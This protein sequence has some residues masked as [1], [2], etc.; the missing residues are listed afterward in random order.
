MEVIIAIDT[1]GKWHIID[2]PEGLTR[3]LIALTDALYCAQEAQKRDDGPTDL[4]NMLAG[5][6]RSNWDG[7][8]FTDHTILWRG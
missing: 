4:T 6:Y 5:L 8:K 3:A 1:D 7:D 2:H